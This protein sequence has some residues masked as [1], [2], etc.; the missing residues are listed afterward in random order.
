MAFSSQWIKTA[1]TLP[2]HPKLK[3]LAEILDISEPEALGRLVF[4]WV[5]A[6]EFRP[7]GIFENA[8]EVAAAM[9]WTKSTPAELLDALRNCGGFAAG[10]VDYE[11]PDD[12]GIVVLHDW[13]DY[14]GGAVTGGSGGLHALIRPSKRKEE[15]RKEKKEGAPENVCMKFEK[16]SPSPQTLTGQDLENYKAFLKTLS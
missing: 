1:T 11:T 13:H 16:S 5:Y 7:A 2:R 15:K 6:L 4:L 3:R 8:A 10:F 9:C 14:T 12:E